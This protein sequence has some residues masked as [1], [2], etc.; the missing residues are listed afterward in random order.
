MFDFSGRKHFSSPL[1]PSMLANIL[2]V[3]EQSNVLIDIVVTSAVIKAIVAK[4][5]P[6]SL[7]PSRKKGQISSNHVIHESDRIALLKTPHV[8]SRDS[9]RSFGKCLA[10]FA[11]VHAKTT[12]ENC[13]STRRPVVESVMSTSLS[14]A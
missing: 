13:I 14:V 11:I 2:N 7:G 1:K 5:F 4:V 12:T 6:S 10:T 8:S 3:I 9:Q